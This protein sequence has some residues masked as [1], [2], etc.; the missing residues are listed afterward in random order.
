[1]SDLT[2][3][4]SLPQPVVVLD[5]SG[6]I[7]A[8]NARFT[9]SRYATLDENLFGVSSVS[10]R[11][12]F[13]ASVSRPVRVTWGDVK[14]VTATAARTKWEGKAAVLISLPDFAAPTKL[15]RLNE[16]VS[17]L[18]SQLKNLQRLRAAED[19]VARLEEREK[20][21]QLAEEKR[22]RLLQSMAHQ[23]RTPL[24]AI[25]GA[26]HFLIDNPAI[27]G[28]EPEALELLAHGTAQTEAIVDRILMASGG[29]AANVPALQTAFSP[30]QTVMRLISE[31]D[32]SISMSLP[33]TDTTI[34]G[35]AKAFKIAMEN[36]LDNAIQHGGPNIAV[37]VDATDLDGEIVFECTVS[38]DGPGLNRMLRNHLFEAG[39]SYG[40]EALTEHLGL[41]LR[42]IK[43]AVDRLDGE[44]SLD[45]SPEAGTTV[46]FAF[47][48][49]KTSSFSLAPQIDSSALKILVVD[50]HSTNRRVLSRILAGMDLV[51]DTAKDGR[52][53]LELAKLHDFNLI[54]MDLSMPIMD[55]FEATRAIRALPLTTQPT[56]V[57]LTAHNLEAV[58]KKCDLAGFDTVLNK[59]LRADEIANIVGY[60]GEPKS[61]N[62]TAIQKGRVIDECGI[63]CNA[64]LGALQNEDLPKVADIVHKQLGAALTVGLTELSE[65]LYSAEAAA[66]N[67]DAEASKFHILRAAKMLKERSLQCDT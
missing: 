31:R 19:K 41:G 2:L 33:D 47:V 44:I 62:L 20:A 6:Q 56:I 61:D 50:D 55:G 30:A 27:K 12:V 1:M 40:E 60:S 63:A 67:D 45:S 24:N 10:L 29:P 9:N 35:D 49:T 25:N 53:A 18:Q 32:T 11:Q 7:I 59:P 4:N 3:F 57:A 51:V 34:L 36:L 23:I 54:F 17:K 39:V 21:Y 28:L 22:L 64:A 5:Q 14:A 38:D 46:T 42:L 15:N 8:R 26:A 66:R 52:E 48:A 13:A 65:R 43:I 16:E 58:Q 37:K